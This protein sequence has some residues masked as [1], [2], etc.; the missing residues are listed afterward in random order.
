[1]RQDV[2]SGRTRKYPNPVPVIQSINQSTKHKPQRTPAYTC[3]RETMTTKNATE[4]NEQQQQ[5]PSLPP[6]Q[7]AATALVASI[8]YAT[9]EEDDGS[10]PCSQDI[11]KEE[12]KRTSTP[13]PPP[14][15]SPSDNNSNSNNNKPTTTQSSPK[16][17]SPSKKWSYIKDLWK[18]ATRY[19]EESFIYSLRI[20]VAMFVASLFTL[21]NPGNFVFP[22]TPWILASTAVVGWQNTLDTATGVKRAIERTVGT[23][24]G[25]ALGLAVGF[26]SLPLQHNKPGQASL[27]GF[28]TVA[29]CFGMPYLTA[30]VG[31]RGSYAAR[32][33]LV[34]YTIISLSFYTSNEPCHPAGW[35]M[36]VWRAIDILLGCFIGA[37]SLIIHPRSMKGM[38][39]KRVKTQ[40]QTVGESTFQVLETACHS[41]T[42]VNRQTMAH[43]DD[44][45]TAA[46]GSNNNHNKSSSGGE[47]TKFETD[48]TYIAYI[49]GAHGWKDCNDLLSMLKYD[50]TLL[51]MSKQ[52]KMEFQQYM[53]II[54]HRVFRM[55]TNLVV[56]ASIVRGAAASIAR[57]M[58]MSHQSTTRGGGG[59]QQ[60]DDTV[61]PA[62]AAVDT[63]SAFM[64]LRDIGQ[65][66]QTLLNSKETPEDRKTA[67]TTLVT[68]DL[69]LV[70]RLVSQEQEESV[71]RRHQLLAAQ[72]Q[73]QPGDDHESMDEK[74]E[75]L[76]GMLLSRFDT[77][78]RQHS[79]LE[80]IESH[81]QVSLFF[82]LVEHLIIR[83]TCLY[84]LWKPELY[85]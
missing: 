27:L 54:S 31:L 77:S 72:Q 18:K 41:F 21:V 28:T 22:Q 11:I 63:E 66:I 25:A 57:E 15:A 19:D 4:K 51:S 2:C 45:L 58:T 68:H 52:E 81:Q 24:I 73:Q 46:G 34:S 10:L 82:L 71:K 3:S 70:G 9:G 67:F 17:K 56:L 16:K 78:S 13:P 60:H 20:A 80:H 59:Q 69:M 43:W 47:V 74:L 64:L 83:A 29:F 65:R 38:I 12:S 23:A 14:P 42:D 53:T 26:I 32:L 49:K 7:T 40:V 50:H 6:P 44:M 76:Q 33:C 36:G 84:Q 30:N 55:H 85:D 35:Y 48:P 5:P 79:P 62:T 39:V 75:Q 37:A 1:M 8:P 61:T